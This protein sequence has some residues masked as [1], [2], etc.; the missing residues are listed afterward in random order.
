MRRH[1]LT[2]CIFDSV[3][4]SLTAFYQDLYDNVRA[5]RKERTHIMECS[6]PLLLRRFHMSI[7]SFGESGLL[8]VNTLLEET[9][10]SREGHEPETHQ[11]DSRYVDRNGIVTVCSHCRRTQNVLQPELWEWAPDSWTMTRAS[12][13]GYVS[14]ASTIITGWPSSEALAPRLVSTSRNF[15]ASS[16]GE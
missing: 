3:P 14:S 5:T 1:Q 4:A 16:S 13:T 11:D 9:P 12:A 10:H 2:R 8:T 6:S 7:R 15:A